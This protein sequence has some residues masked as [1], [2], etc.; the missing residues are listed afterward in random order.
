LPRTHI[1]NYSKASQVDD[2]LDADVQDSA[3][4]RAATFDADGLV[5]ALDSDLNDVHKCRAS[6]EA[7]YIISV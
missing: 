2:I 5:E 4:F 1:Y 6:E 7:R 3:D